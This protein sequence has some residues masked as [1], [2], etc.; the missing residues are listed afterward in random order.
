MVML[1][2]HLFA[3]SITAQPSEAHILGHSFLKLDI[4]DSLSWAVLIFSR[5]SQ[6]WNLVLVGPQMNFSIY[7]INHITDFVE[8]SCERLPLDVT[9]QL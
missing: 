4:G 7:H 8:I 1:F 6:Q 2:V 5:N 3:T 9:G